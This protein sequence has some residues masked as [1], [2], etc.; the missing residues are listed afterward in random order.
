MLR[1]MTSKERVLTTFARQEPDRVPINFKANPG[2]DQRVKAHYG[3][4]SDDTSVLYDILGVDFRHV[5]APY[6][7]APLHAEQPDRRVDPLWGWVTRYVEHESGSYWDYCDF[8]LQDADEAMVADWPFPSP[9]D[10]DYSGVAGACRERQQYAVHV[11]G[12][13]LACIMNTAGFLR[14][15]EQVFVDLALD[16]PAGLL[17]IDR[18]LNVQLEVTRRTLEAAAGGVDF[19]WLGEDLGTQ[20]GP[21]ISMETFRKHI[22][23]RQ[24]PFFDLAKAYG[25]P[26]MIHTC[27]SSSWAYDDYIEMGLTVADTLQPEATDM[28]PAY[29]KQRFGDRLAFHGCISTAGPVAYGTVEDTMASCRDTLE[30]MMPGGGYCFAPTHSLQD[31][32]PTENVVAMYETVHRYGR[33]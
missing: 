22:R 1:V 29:L 11:G 5:G 21:I 12:A 3:L 10:H 33:Y 8:P 30:I 26:V 25:L 13:G 31:N 19:M 18:M 15:M 9:D 32:S 4:K 27:G 16:E 23:P 24:Q 7:G 28:A 17:L 6:T 14:G 2:I 20:K